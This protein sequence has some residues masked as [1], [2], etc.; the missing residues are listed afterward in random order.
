[1]ITSIGICA[2]IVALFALGCGFALYCW[3]G[4]PA[5]EAW[6]KF[7]NVVLRGDKGRSVPDPPELQPTE[8]SR[9]AEQ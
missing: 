9:H 1:M 3:R 6:G 4:A 7:V 8:Q 5:L 2:A